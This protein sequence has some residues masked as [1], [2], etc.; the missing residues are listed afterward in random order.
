[1]ESSVIIKINQI[2][3]NEHGIDLSLKTTTDGIMKA[4]ETIIMKASDLFF[5]RY[6]QNV[7]A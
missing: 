6:W 2:Q 1:M 4:E 5:Y 7:T 3:I